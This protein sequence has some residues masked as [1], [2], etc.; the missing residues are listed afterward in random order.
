MVDYKLDKNIFRS[1]FHPILQE[2]LFWKYVFYILMFR[3]MYKKKYI[4]QSFLMQMSVFYIKEI[5]LCKYSG[6]WK[7]NLFIKSYYYYFFFIYITAQCGIKFFRI[8]AQ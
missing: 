8:K 1:R 3:G 6:C 5:Y 7:M 4:C 2:F